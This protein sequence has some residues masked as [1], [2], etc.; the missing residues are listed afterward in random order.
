M[1]RFILRS[2]VYHWRI[3][4]AVALGVA[5]ATAVLTGALLVGDSVRGSLRRLTLDRL[6]RIDEVLV[7]DRFFAAQQAARL[8]ASTGFRQHFSA[9]VPAILFPRGTLE[10]QGATQSGRAAQVLIVGCGEAFW[11]LGNASYRPARTPGRDEIV[12]NAPLAGELQAE[13]GDT[14]VLR[15]PKSNLVPADSPLGRKSD[16]IRA[17]PGLRVIEIIP[18][19]SLGRFSLTAT[20]TTPRNAYV[21][22]ETLQAALDQEGRVNAILV[23]GQS[24]RVPPGVEAQAALADAFQ[25]ALAD[26]GFAVHR[27]R[28]TFQPDVP[29]ASEEVVYDYLSLTTDRM[30][31]APQAERAAWR[32]WK[33]FGAQPVSTY[34][35]N[36][37]EKIGAE[38]PSPVIPYSLVSAVD[39]LPGL[40]PLLAADGKTPL[41]LAADEMAL[42]SWAAADLKAKPGDRIRVT[43]YRPET[44]HGRLE[45]G[46]AEFVLKAIVPLTEPNRPY[47][48]NRPAEYKT[49]PTLANDP[50]LTPTVEGVTDQESIDKWEAP[51]PVDYN[52]VRPQDDEYWRNHRTTPKAFISL[53]A[54]KRL[55]GSRFGDITS[56]RVAVP[57]QTQGSAFTQQLET[58]LR[59]ELDRDRTALGFEFLPVKQRGIAAS[60]GATPFDVLF[61]FLSFFVIV[62]A[63]M[64]VALQFRLGV[65][66]RAREI[67]TLLAVGFR[68][69]LAARLFAIEGAAVAAIGAAIGVAVGVG[70][71]WLMIAGLKT[72]WIGAI[73]TPFLQLFVQP[74]SL[75]IGYGSGVAICVLTIVLSLWRT[76]GIS[77]RRLLAGQA[78][79]ADE[80]V[81]APASRW[82][83]I[84][85]VI[86]LAA[87]AALAFAAAQLGGE[88]QAGAFVGSGTLVLAAILTLIRRYFKTG[89]RAGGRT[90]GWSLR[91]LAG[92][93]VARNPGRSTLT[94]GLMA[95]ASFLI[96][97]MSSF[98]LAPTA[99][100]TG[101]FDLVAESSEPVFGDWSTPEGREAL[102][103]DRAAALEGGTVLPLRLQAGDDA[104]CNN[105]YQ[106]SQ[107]RIL[108]VTEPLVRYFDDPAV[109]AF[110]WAASAA[111]SPA[112]K[113]NSWRLLSAGGQ[114]FQAVA[115]S[116]EAP[117]PAIPVVL[118]KNMALYSLHLYGGIGEEFE[119]TY[120]EVGPIRFRVA[121]LLSNS[122]LQGS[123][124]VGEADFVSRFPE[125]SGYRYFLIKSPADQSPAVASA[126]EDRLG[127]QGF[128]AVSARERLQD[129][130]AVQNTYLSTFQS[131]GAL[132]LLLG[133]FG[134]AAVQIR[135]VIERRGELALLRAAGFRRRRLARLV[136]I[137]ALTLLAGGLATGFLAALVTTLPQMLVGDA[138]IPLG[139]LTVLLA[140]VLAVGCLTSLTSVRTVLRAPLMAA[141]REE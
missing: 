59:A 103:A 43:F 9:A 35:A 19:E 141:L 64:L 114:P 90:G 105:L 134:L 60:D 24:P 31:L 14:V 77:V 37:L 23:A 40:G 49:R 89:G 73:S 83:W 69:P 2:L 54:G 106:A 38:A 96:V 52:R 98:R 5:A 137:E 94:V 51:F 42:N 63:L 115:P 55:W 18:A 6:G 84:G 21:A 65:E 118:D 88:A 11:E 22:S 138:S 79:G 139:D 107:P 120:P 3:H 100:G 140:I 70:Y 123:L 112:D 50:D 20:Q 10:K 97:A 58:L 86:L 68:R 91:W 126:L 13:V 130:F 74:L 81:Y 8:E 71:A 72:W 95:V 66:R 33:S 32:A 99:A 125:V 26:H 17:I 101:G 27:V 127:D 133:T 122:V 45:E 36:A 76:K 12:L 92:R 119:L 46:S 48:R 78:V 28:R 87:A 85:A 75:A 124:L 117:P 116:D 25:P 44:T 61:L 56:V 132:G 108:G 80:L 121:G 131:L 47:R 113:A 102:L 62:A 7:T 128:D 67:G 82:G 136:M 30:L 111:E 129:L 104:S 16:R 29:Q 110:A 41:D 93:N 15:L 1:W 34:L 109:Q 135:N 39:S 57:P 4:L 53:A